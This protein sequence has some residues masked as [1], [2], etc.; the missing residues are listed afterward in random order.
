MAGLL[1]RRHWGVEWEKE[2]KG[3]AKIHDETFD[4]IYVLSWLWWWSHGYMHML[5]FIKCY[6]SE[7]NY[8][9]KYW[10]LYHISPTVVDCCSKLFFMSIGEVFFPNPWFELGCVTFFGQWILVGMTQK[11]A[12]NVVLHLDTPHLDFALLWRWLPLGHC[13]LFILGIRV[14]T[15]GVNLSPTHKRPSCTCC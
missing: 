1:S 5:K 10:A 2:E 6:I 11:G 7:K 12:L 4:V 8:K 15:C 14:N 13:W 9:C 3:T